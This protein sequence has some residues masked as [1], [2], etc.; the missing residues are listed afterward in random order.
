M[1]KS[2]QLK[3]NNLTGNRKAPIFFMLSI[4]ASKHIYLLRL[5]NP[6]LF[7]ALIAVFIPDIMRNFFISFSKS[8]LKIRLIE[9]NFN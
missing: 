4:K 6:A 3:I 1:S 9:N 8:A 5:V 2:N 7:N